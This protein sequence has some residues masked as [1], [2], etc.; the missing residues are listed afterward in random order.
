[1]LPHY[2]AHDVFILQVYGKKYWTV[3]D[4][5]TETP[6]LNSF[7][8]IFN[9]ENLRNPQELTV[10]AG[11]MLYI[12]R[13]VPHEAHT[14]DEPSL[15]VVIG[16]YPAQWLDVF[17]NAIKQIAN[18]YTPLRKALPYGYLKENQWTEEY[19][20]AFNARFKEI[21]DEV[22]RRIAPEFGMPEVQEDYR[23]KQIPIGDGHFRAIDRM[24]EIALNTP[25]V[26]RDDMYC[27]IQVMNN[28]CRI[29]F[30]G[31]VIKG[32]APVENAFR[33]VAEADGPFTPNDLPRLSDKNK[34]K[35]AAR[36][37]RG[38]LLRFVD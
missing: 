6:L 11:D 14:T 5:P 13:G 31:N 10:S 34:I 23:N 15:H 12:P 20:E 28:F 16:L 21:M 4:S 18:Q 26:K 37:V 1:M 35:I 22:S 3:Y 29:L 9:R 25:L 24:G 8:P 36:L 7:Q 30:P 38:G 32:P 27:R 33:F 2:D 17:S 19:K